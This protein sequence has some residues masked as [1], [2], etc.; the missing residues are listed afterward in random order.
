MNG[1]GALDKRVSD[2]LLRRA[3]TQGLVTV[4]GTEGKLSASGRG[5]QILPRPATQAALERIPGASRLALA[6]EPSDEVLA[7]GTGATGV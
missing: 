6:V 3:L 7:D 5:T 1:A 2:R 4:H